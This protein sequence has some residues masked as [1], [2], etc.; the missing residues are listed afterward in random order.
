MSTAVFFGGEVLAE[1]GREVGESSHYKNGVAGAE[2]GVS[3]GER[4]AILAA[5]GGAMLPAF[6]PLGKPVRS[7]R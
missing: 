7:S 1:V 2:G 6:L 3:G 4:G 5:G